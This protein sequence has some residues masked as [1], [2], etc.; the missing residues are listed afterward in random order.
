MMSAPT[1]CRFFRQLLG[2]LRRL[3]SVRVAIVRILSSQQIEHSAQRDAY[4]VRPVVQLVADLVQ[5]LLEQVRVEQD[6]DLLARW[7]EMPRAVARARGRRAGTR[8]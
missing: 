8:R 1:F 5:R 3:L 6:A 2:A 4:P 7:R